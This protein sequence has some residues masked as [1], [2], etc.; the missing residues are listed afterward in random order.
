MMKRFGDEGDDISHPNAYFVPKKKKVLTHQEIE[1]HFPF[2]REKFYFRYRTAGQSKG[3]YVWVDVNDPNKNVPMY[4]GRVF[5]KVLRLE[6]TKNDYD[7]VEKEDGDDEEEDVDD[8][9]MVEEDNDESLGVKKIKPR[10]KRRGTTEEMMN[11]MNDD[12]ISVDDEEEEEDDDDDDDDDEDDDEDEDD[13]L[14]GNTSSGGMVS[15]N[16]LQ[17]AFDSMIHPNP[18][19]TNGPIVPEAKVEDKIADVKR[20]LDAHDAQLDAVQ[21][22]RSR[23]QAKLDNWSTET[24]GQIK[25]IR[26]LL[27][28]MHTVLYKGA[29]WKEVGMSDLLTARDIQKQF[30]KA[31][32]V[33]HTDKLPKHAT[34]KDIA[35]AEIIYNALIKA[36]K[37]FDE[38][39]GG[40]R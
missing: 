29:R 16:D 24:G 32:R 31:M 11:F 18:K 21:D 40:R 17:N 27:S 19:Y 37:T 26:A 38:K 2:Q 10:L 20:N 8:F 34:P 1:R 15:V 36:K 23:N 28:T 4:Y 25:N 33:V 7:F 3:E 14:N 6:S 13:V 39:E 30:L 22:E 9:V 5:L 35:I 12:N